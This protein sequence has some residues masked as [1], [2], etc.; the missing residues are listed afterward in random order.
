M[1]FRHFFSSGNDQDTY[2]RQCARF[3]NKM[4][5]VQTWTTDQMTDF[6]V[7]WPQ[8]DLNS[9]NYFFLSHINLLSFVFIL[10]FKI[11]RVFSF[12]HSFIIHSFIHSL[13]LLEHSGKKLCNDHA[14]VRLSSNRS[15]ARTNR[16]GRTTWVIMI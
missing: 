5:R 12:I 4:C 6:K 15:Q 14:I 13:K 16:S 8:R 2:P 1:T 7:V 11:G 10:I 9:Q 3:G